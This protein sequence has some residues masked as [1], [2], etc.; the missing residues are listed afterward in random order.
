MEKSLDSPVAI[1]KT[2]MTLNITMDDSGPAGLGITV[3]GRVNTTNS[4]PSQVSG[5]AGIYIKSIVPGGA[6]ALDN[7]LSVN[8]QLLS[9]N[10]QSLVGKS[11]DDALR[12]L[13][14]AL[15]KKTTNIQLVGGVG[16]DGG[17][18]GGR[19]MRTCTSVRVHCTFRKF[20]SSN[21]CEKFHSQTANA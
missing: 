2:V 16:V 17:E 8:D 19:S 20:V 3:H 6:A 15:A 21:I 18:G 11:N 1:G 7:R 12:T 13:K 10:S 14:E 4:L 9:V 5:D